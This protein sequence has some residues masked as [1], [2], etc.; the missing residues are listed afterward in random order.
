AAIV[1]HDAPDR[2][3]AAIVGSAFGYAGQVCI[4][5]QRLYVHAAVADRVIEDIVHRARALV[6]EQP[7]HAKGIFGPM[8]DEANAERVAS[9]VEDAV[10]GGAELLLGGTRDG[11][12]HA[13]TVL[14][15]D[16]D[17]RGLEIVD[18]EVFG[19][20]LT[21]HRYDAWEDALQMADGTRYG[22]QA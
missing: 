12:K 3:A 10:D 22:L 5:T 6:P 21:I 20:V 14:L 17:G 16:G 15:I 9:W 4:K 19:P 18:E 1:H 8:I 7:I 11:S 2:A 13:P